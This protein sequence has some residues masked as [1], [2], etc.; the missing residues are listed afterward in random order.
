MATT[1]QIVEAIIQSLPNK[2]Q[3]DIYATEIP[4]M[5]P[6]KITSLK[7]KQSY[8]PDMVI[9]SKDLMHIFSIETNAPVVL[10]DSFLKKVQLFSIHAEKH[11]GRLYIVAKSNFISKVKVTLK[12]KYRNIDYLTIQ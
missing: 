11:A 9:K 5:R 7:T 2:S 4:N 6:P 12:N 3:L 10:S 8:T 1:P